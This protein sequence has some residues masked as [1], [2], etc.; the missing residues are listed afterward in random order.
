MNVQNVIEHS[1]TNVIGRNTRWNAAIDSVRSTLIV[2]LWSD[3]NASLLRKYA[4]LAARLC[5]G[6]NYSTSFPAT[7][8]SGHTGLVQCKICRKA[9]K[10]K[11]NVTRHE[12]TRVKGSTWEKKC[13]G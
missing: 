5:P 12:R 3:Q 8:A 6:V 1:G 9:F 4:S 13:N 11:T 2:D 10:S 7:H